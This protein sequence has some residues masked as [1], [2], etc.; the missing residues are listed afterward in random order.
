MAPMPALLRGWGLCSEGPERSCMGH[1]VGPSLVRWPSD[2]QGGAE[3][4]HTEG[5]FLASCRCSLT[6]PYVSL[7]SYWMDNR[8]D[9]QDKSF[10]CHCIT[11]MT[12]A[13]LHASK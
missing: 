11:N 7:P 3:K 9:K 5:A 10:P 1:P 6:S 4:G 8:E 13:L 12:N 2:H